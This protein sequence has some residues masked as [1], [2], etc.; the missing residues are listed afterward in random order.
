MEATIL[1]ISRKSPLTAPSGKM[2][3]Y[4]AENMD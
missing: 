3:K 4:K 2:M 1:K